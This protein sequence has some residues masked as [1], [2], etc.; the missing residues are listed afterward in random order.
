[1]FNSLCKCNQYSRSLEK[2][3]FVSKTENLTKICCYC[4]NKDLQ[5]Y[6]V[7]K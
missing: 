1:M 7:A 5:N 3:A 6:Y 4:R 2:T